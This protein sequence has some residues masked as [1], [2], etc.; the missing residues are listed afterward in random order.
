[1]QSE[2]LRLVEQGPVQERTD[3]HEQTR[4]DR[5][6]PDQHRRLAGAGIQQQAAP[7]GEADVADQRYRES[8]RVQKPTSLVATAPQ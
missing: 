5:G 2:V 7:Q 6:L 8:G 4:Y 1:M 3:E